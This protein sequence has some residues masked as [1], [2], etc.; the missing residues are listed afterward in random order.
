[1]NRKQILDNAA[2]AVLKDRQETYGPPEDSFTTIAELWT[3]YLQRRKPGPLLPYEI[4]TMLIL[5]KIARVIKSPEHMDNWCDE[6]GYA[7]CGGELA[8][9]KLQACNTSS[10]QNEMDH[11]PDSSTLTDQ[12]VIAVSRKGHALISQTLKVL[13]NEELI[14]AE[15]AIFRPTTFN[16][17]SYKRLMAIL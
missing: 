9:P 1:M 14:T 3:I 4:A 15:M 6:A 8:S 17:G 11:R 12:E 13:I 10:T 5:M 7:A 2:A 16:W